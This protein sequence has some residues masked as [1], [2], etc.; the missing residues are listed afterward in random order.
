MRTRSLPIDRLRVRWREN[1]EGP[2]I[3]FLHGW[4]TNSRLWRAV[5][6]RLAGAY[7][8]APDLVGY[9]ASTGQAARYDLRVGAQA[10]VL[11]TWLRTLG[12]GPAVLVG[13]EL[14]GGVAQVL[15][16]RHP[17][18]AVGLVLV[19]SAGLGEWPNV[20]Q[21]LAS[22]AGPVLSWTPLAFLEPAF[23]RYVQAGHVDE[24]VAQASIEEH[25]PSYAAWGARALVCQAQAMRR[26][27]TRH[28]ARS[29]AALR[30][31]T[32]VVWGARDP[33]LEVGR[34]QRLA[35][36]LGATLIELPEQSHFVPEDAPDA[37]VRAIAE[38][39]TDVRR[40]GQS[41]R[42]RIGHL[43]LIESRA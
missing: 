1:G 20:L 38:V 39:L 13:H 32:R 26:E 27:D 2:P 6:P 30:L 43:E 19:N 7:T 18:L 24:D 40:A 28:V 4:P 22:V 23:R 15:A 5:M 42:R 11:S 25:W 31:P 33:Y 12:V 8:L 10:D 16:A 29:L 17:E 14:G 34:G 37:I 21:R 41:P 36:A 3:V 9:G 35:N